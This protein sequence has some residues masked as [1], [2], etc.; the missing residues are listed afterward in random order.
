[1]QCLTELFEADRYGG[2]M[3]TRRLSASASSPVPMLP[4]APR[5][6]VVVAPP[7]MR[8]WVIDQDRSSLALPHEVMFV[9][10]I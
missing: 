3:A 8:S 5:N 9:F 7:A 6:A 4:K 10:A 1:M 2:T